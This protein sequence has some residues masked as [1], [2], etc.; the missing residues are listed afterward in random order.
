MH[1]VRIRIADAGRIALHAEKIMD[2]IPQ[3][4]VQQY[5]R[6]KKKQEADQELAAGF[7]LK[8]Y[9]N[10]S[11]DAQFVRLGH[12][13]PV[14]KSG[15]SYFNLSHS[16]E[17]TVLA[18]AD[19]DIGVDIEQ[20]KDVHWPT[21]QKIFTAEQRERLERTGE[22]GRPEL[23]AKY[24]TECEAVLKLK[25]TGFAA[26]TVTSDTGPGRTGSGDGRLPLKV[27]SFRY[28]EYM[29]A[30]AAYG[31]FYVSVEEDRSYLYM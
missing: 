31:A 1:L 8:K 12:G 13:K 7:L 18:A 2:G 28:K 6:I 26:E 21:V 16:G 9:L 23:F 19:I 27:Y 30:C 3:Y 10:V 15:N 14:L 20:I 25:G 22:A 4:Y 11:S 24:W 5:R 29:I 17:Y